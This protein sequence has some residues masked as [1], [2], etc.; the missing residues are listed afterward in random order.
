MDYVILF[1][2]KIPVNNIAFTVPG[3]QFH[4]Y[5]YGIII[6]VGFVLALVWGMRKAE[7]HGIDKDKLIDVV[8]VGFINAI[9][10]ARAYYIIFSDMVITSWKQ[11]F[12]IHD[13]GI[14]IYGAVIGAL[15]GG[16]IMCKIRKVNLL[17]MFDLA[18]PGFLIGQ[19]I[20]RWGNFVN[21]EAYGD[22][23]GS[24]WFGMTG[25]RIAR[26]MGPNV[27]VHPCFLYESLWCLACF[28]LLWQIGRRRKFDGQIFCLYLI[29]Y[30]IG[31]FFI[32]GLRTDSLYIDLVF[33]ELR[34]SQVLAALLVIGGTVLYFV[35]REAERR[36][37]YKEYVNLFDE[38]TVSEEAAANGS[39]N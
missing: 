15:L 6:A 22:A 21:Q 18:M 4:I 3:T 17:A 30:S 28:I 31:R 2:I 34:V 33:A 8:L 14:A 24:S 23:T 10:G 1:G 37:H 35:L 39:D 38:D 12:A 25:S 16:G 36:S 19:C 11:V 9:I 27:L 13:G 29:T 32:E 5:W 26:E 20:G 7:S